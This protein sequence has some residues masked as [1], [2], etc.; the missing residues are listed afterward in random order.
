[1]EFLEMFIIFDL[2][3]LVV[4]TCAQIVRITEERKGKNGSKPV[5]KFAGA[6]PEAQE[7]IKNLLAKRYHEMKDSEIR[8]FVKDLKL[9]MAIRTKRIDGKEGTYIYWVGEDANIGKYYV[10]VDGF[11]LGS[12]KIKM[13][14]VAD[15]DIK[16]NPAQLV[17]TGATVGGVT[18]GGFHV[19][20]AYTSAQYKSSKK[21]NLYLEPSVNSVKT[22]VRVEDIFLGEEM[23]KQAKGMLF[24]K[25]LSDSRL[26]MCGE[27]SEYKKSL[28]AGAVKSGNIMLVEARQKDCYLDSLTTKEECSRILSFITQ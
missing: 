5:S 15:Y 2:I 16:Y 13:K 14:E 19:E 10:D 9:K 27:I 26:L 7:G 20:D 12:P 28:L 6:T 11:H 22:T 18:T 3:L 17:Y 23:A 21:Y 25:R 4:C 24:G 8:Q 1:M